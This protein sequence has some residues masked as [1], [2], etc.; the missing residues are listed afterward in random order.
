[1]KEFFNNLRKFISTL[2]LVEQSQIV[3]STIVI[4]L[5]VTIL[6]IYIFT[7]EQLRLLDFFT[8]ITVGIFGFMI[9]YF[10]AK[11]G[12]Q[13]N[14]QHQQLR[15]LNEVS[16]AVS[17]SVDLKIVL[18]SA[19]EKICELFKADFGWIFLIED[20]KL[21]L[22]YQY[23][24]QTKIFPEKIAL[25]EKWIE[26]LKLDNE[27]SQSFIDKQQFISKQLRKFN[28]QDWASLPL[29]RNNDFIGAILIA[30]RNP[31]VF[32]KK[33]LETLTTFRNQIYVAL[34]N[35]YLF[36]QLKQSEKMYQDLYENL[37]DMYHSV[38]KKGI[39]VSCNKTETEYL[40][41]KKDELIG[42]LVTVLYPTDQHDTVMERINY[43]FNK[44]VELKGIEEI[45][46]KKDKDQII[47]S[48]NTS[49]VY[50]EHGEPTLLRIV[51]RDITKQKMMEE[52]IIQA[53]KID[54]IG[55]LA[56][57][58]AHDFN[59]ILN[60]ILGPASMM[61]RKLTPDDK[62]YKY[63][64]LIED[65]ARR[66][67]AVTRQLLTFSRKSNVYFKVTNINKIVED[68][69]QLFE[70]SVPKI[71]QVKKNLQKDIL[72]VNVDEGQIEQALLNL[73]LNAQDAMPD[74]GV[75]TVS[76]RS[77]DLNEAL[78]AVYS[79]VPP[80][81]YVQIKIIDT[82][83]GIPKEQ[84]TRIF[85]PFYTTK[86]QSKGTG[87]GLSVVYGVVKSHKG[88]I[89]VESELNIGTAFTIY[90]PR[91]DK[92]KQT[93]EE[94]GE[95]TIVGGNEHILIVDDDTGAN[96]VAGDILKELGYKVTI[97]QDGYEAIENFQSTNY[98]D[99]VILD[100]NMP[101]ISGKDVFKKM[102]QLNPSIKVLICSGYSDTIINDDEF[103]KE[104]DGYLHKPYMYED[105]AKSVRD[106]LDK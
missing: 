23:K 45:M 60:S 98:Y 59:N 47:V 54:S 82:G 92:I 90:L 104:I 29:E 13:I 48:I 103:L 96:I 74:G 28:I 34:S 27:I 83:K 100:L 44:R 93:E 68:T 10:F 46:Q 56:G 31:N 41:Y 95:T 97:S 71:I 64:T 77:V 85:D 11:Y 73:F 22:K 14:E 91:V 49:L 36:F 25:D 86:P 72:L 67:A 57:G 42:K 7:G 70:R 99:L 79:D 101:G 52:K 15:A 65:S 5:M 4:V 80:G 21:Q 33:Q 102:R 17:H 58:V 38:D 1:M 84:I 18:Q 66:G 12:L 62:Y 105:L 19:L 39:I 3:A 53:Q 26:F 32:K 61:K 51:A 55:N 63:I 40:G 8:L 6:A 16:Q 43:I 106:V 50:D 88:S 78:P 9:V 89:I 35:A 94:P 87:L 81:K 20:N 30:S 75:I 69:V 76:T 2:G 24:I 37:P